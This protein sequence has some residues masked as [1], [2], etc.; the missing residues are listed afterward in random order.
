M[1]QSLAAYAPAVCVLLLAASPAT[2]SAA[3]A[4]GASPFSRTLVSRA[5]IRK[6]NLAQENKGDDDDKI[7][8]PDA[9]VPQGSGKSKS[10]QAFS[11]LSENRLTLRGGAP[12][13]ESKP[14]GPKLQIVFVS[15]EIAPW[16]VTGG[17]GAVCS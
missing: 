1:L 3:L 12:A 7:N 16:S 5:Q 8:D 13:E 9:Y 11:L 2:S 10:C 17:L 15:A 4:T 6:L 14:T